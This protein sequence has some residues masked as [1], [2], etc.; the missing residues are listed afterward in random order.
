MAALYLIM[1]I[2]GQ[3]VAI[4][5]GPVE[6]VVEFDAIVPVPKVPPHIA[7]LAALRSRVLTIVD[8]NASLE[9]P[10]PPPAETSCAVI[11]MV[12]GH[13][14]GLLVDEVRDVVLIAEMPRPANL[15]LGGGWARVVRGIV[16][17]DGAALPLL[18]PAALIEGPGTLAA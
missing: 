14:Y 8:C 9:L 6:S 17:H 4:A 11:V 15:A 3:R 10:K 12:D 5:A 13:H 2:A 18:D 1:T 7:G 16:T